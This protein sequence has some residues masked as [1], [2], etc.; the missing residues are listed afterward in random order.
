MYCRYNSENLKF[1]CSNI[2]LIS[3]YSL[4]RSRSNLKVIHNDAVRTLQKKYAPL[5]KAGG[6][7]SLYNIDKSVSHKKF[8]IY[9]D[10]Q[11]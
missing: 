1:I 2:I 7:R 6:F 8:S 9:V 11:L 3:T 10:R 4:L 5:V